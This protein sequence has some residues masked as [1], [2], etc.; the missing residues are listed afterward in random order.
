MRKLYCL[1]MALC[2]C[3][4]AYA[5]EKWLV[6]QDENGLCTV[7][8]PIAPKV[9]HSSTK[10]EDG[11]EV[12]VTTYV[13]DRGESAM[14]VMVSDLAGRTKDKDLIL[15]DCIDGVAEG[16]TLVSKVNDELDGQ[17]GRF[18]VI[19]DSTG[20]RYTDRAFVV[21]RKLY[22]VMAVTGAN[23]P[24]DQLAEAKRFNSSLHFP[25]KVK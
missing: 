7:E 11:T 10:I 24:A 17:V 18:A 2:F 3:V 19:M 5:L 9:T 12:A 21:D 15:D 14:I 22:Q 4:S 6:F 16:K 25:I 23:A 13:I 20:N 8:V 1:L